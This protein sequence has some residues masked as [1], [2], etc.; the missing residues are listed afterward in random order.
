MSRVTTTFSG[1]PWFFSNSKVV[2]SGSRAKIPYSLPAL[3]RSPDMAI[4]RDVHKKVI[5]NMKVVHKKD[6]SMR[7][8]GREVQFASSD[9]VARY[10]DT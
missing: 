3:M 2:R 10:G 4:P 6:S 9:A 7:G 8:K 5:Q 1:S